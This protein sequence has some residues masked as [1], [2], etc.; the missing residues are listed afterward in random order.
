MVN[1]NSEEKW[2]KL[3]NS[4]HEIRKHFS[5]TKKLQ[6]EAIIA[7]HAPL[8][9]LVAAIWIATHYTPFPRECA[10]IRVAIYLLD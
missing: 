6:I 7:Y 3:P 2:F 9:R 1:F 10:S 5:K 8:T 4:T